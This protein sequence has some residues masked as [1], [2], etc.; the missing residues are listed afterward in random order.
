MQSKLV[1][2]SKRLDSLNFKAQD[3]QDIFAKF[4]KMKFDNL[5]TGVTKKGVLD[6]VLACKYNIFTLLSM[7]FSIFTCIIPPF[8]FTFKTYVF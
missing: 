5:L 3:R 1:R 6:K 7:I 8:K 2:D 4:F